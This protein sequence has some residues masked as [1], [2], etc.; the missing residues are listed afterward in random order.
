MLQSTNHLAVKGSERHMREFVDRY[1]NKWRT[2]RFSMGG[3]HIKKN[4]VY[5]YN[6]SK[7]F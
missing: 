7:C 6:I 4:Y 3:S 2:P 5:V 1:R